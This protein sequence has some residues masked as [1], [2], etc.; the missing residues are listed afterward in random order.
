V[1]VI[2]FTPSNSVVY[3]SA[4]VPFA[5]SPVQVSPGV[6]VS[7]LTN[8]RSLFCLVVLSHTVPLSKTSP[9]PM[10]LISNVNPILSVALALSLSFVICI[11]APEL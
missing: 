7:T 6:L 11:G 5:S 2:V 8:K 9:V 4:Y 3:P 10:L 1:Q